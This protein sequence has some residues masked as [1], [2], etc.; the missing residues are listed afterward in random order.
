VLEVILGLICRYYFEQFFPEVDDLTALIANELLHLPLPTEYHQ[1]NEAKRILKI[2]SGILF[3][4]QNFDM[5]LMVAKERMMVSF[6]DIFE[7]EQVVF[8][9]GEIEVGLL[10]FRYH[11]L[12]ILLDKIN[13]RAFIRIRIRH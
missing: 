4:W 13:Q 7:I 11:I 12:I 3:E 2:A 6:I 1:I 8:Q 10:P 9:G 5:R